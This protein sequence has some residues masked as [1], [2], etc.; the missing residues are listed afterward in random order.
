MQHLWMIERMVDII[1]RELHMDPADVRLKNYVRADEMPYVTPSGGVYDGGDYALSLT[2][3]MKLI[4]YEGLRE[5]QAR[6]RKQG[7]LIG[8]G[9]ATA[10]DSGTNNFGQVKILTN[11]NPFFRQLGSCADQH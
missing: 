2:K 7:R 6:A 11:D 5:E 8:I 10:V 3:A 9:I 4:D 1:A